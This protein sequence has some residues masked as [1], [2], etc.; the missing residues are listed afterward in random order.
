M[1]SRSV[2][3]KGFGL[4]VEVPDRVRDAMRRAVRR[5]GRA[6]DPHPTQAAE[7]LTIAPVPAY[8]A[9]PHDPEHAAL[10][11]EEEVARRAELGADG[12]DRSTGDELDGRSWYHTIELPDGRVTP[13]YFDHR[14]LV[15]HYGIPAD[16]SGQRVLDVGTA[17]GFWAFEFEGRG[18]NVTA[19][20]IDSSDD[21]DLPAAGRRVATERGLTYRIGDGFD[22]AA[23]LR[24]SEV[25]RI[26]SNVYELDP[27]HHG[28]FD[29]VHAGDILLHVREPLRALEHI[30]SVTTGMALLSDVFDPALDAA[31][32]P[33]G[34]T[35]YLGGWYMAGWWLPS[36]S[37]LV[38]LVFDA[39][40]SA[41][42]PLVTYQLTGADDRPGGWRVV[43]RASP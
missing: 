41:V 17:D 10:F 21:I 5:D 30:R 38:Q 14:P 24:H 25:E 23:K 4:T 31:S 37:T 39:G 19:V 8:V 42:D 32:D 35:R 22:L 20:D 12:S 43:L 3:A 33:T 27:D 18:G 34:V 7:R 26:V 6:A 11:V 40:F 29:L 28:T 16:L 15:P 13:G 2:R 1:A 9:A 36:L